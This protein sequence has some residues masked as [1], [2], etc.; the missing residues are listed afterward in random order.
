VRACSRI[1]EIFLF[2]TTTSRPSRIPSGRIK[3]EL[4][5]I[6]DREKPRA[7]VGIRIGDKIASHVRDSAVSRTNSGKF[8]QKT[9]S[10]ARQTPGKVR[11][12]IWLTKPVSQRPV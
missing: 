9:S 5:K 2:S 6:M 1:A 11:T 7:R 3:R 12:V 10:L 4:V 8:R